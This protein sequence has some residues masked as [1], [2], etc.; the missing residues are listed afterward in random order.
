MLPP[1]RDLALPLPAD[2]TP[3]VRGDRQAGFTLL[4]VLLVAMLMGLVA[5][6]VTLSM[7]SVKGDREL[8]N[9]SARL[10]AALQQA[11]EQAIMEGRLLGLR[12]EDRA[13][14]FMV[15]S[16][17]DRKWQAIEGDK[18][19]SRHELPEGM[20]LALE[21]EGFSWQSGRDEKA[22]QSREEK[23]RTPQVL[24]FPGS[25]LT[26]FTLTL[27]LDQDGERFLRRYQGDG[28][29]RITRQEEEE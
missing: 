18:L 2:G 20:S 15:R 16:G 1:A 6:A 13:W 3:P 4:E 17:Q 22:E 12:V 23:A 9:Q 7:G 8:E 10:R 5:M 14:Q 24:L 26:P 29:G 21:V 28:F 27:T 25:E 11:Q 19:L